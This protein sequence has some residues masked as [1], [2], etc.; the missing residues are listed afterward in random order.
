MYKDFRDGLMLEYSHTLPAQ[1]L[2]FGG[3]IKSGV[4]VR[5]DNSRAYKGS[6]NISTALK[7]EAD[8]V[9]RTEFI[10]LHTLVMKKQ[11]ERISK[12]HGSKIPLRF[13]RQL[14]EIQGRISKLKRTANDLANQVPDH[15]Y[16]QMNTVKLVKC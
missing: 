15:H 7:D 5:T 6:I 3:T 11:A 4:T 2:K 13:Q 14:Q 16:F 12:G 9:Y 10:P 1:K 8:Y